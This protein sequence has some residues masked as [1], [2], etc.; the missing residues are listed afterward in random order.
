VIGTG[1]IGRRMRQPRLKTRDLESLENGM[2]R[3]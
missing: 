2:F 1:M 3:L